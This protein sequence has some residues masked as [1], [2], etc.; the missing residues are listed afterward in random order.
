MRSGGGR[1]FTSVPFFEGERAE[2]SPAYSGV[3]ARANSNIR[4]LST[5]M[6]PSYGQ[7]NSDS[8]LPGQNGLPW[9]WRFNARWHK[10]WSPI[11]ALRGQAGLI[12]SRYWIELQRQYV[13]ARRAVDPASSTGRCP[14]ATKTWL[15]VACLV[16]TVGGNQKAA[17]RGRVEGTGQ[18]P[19]PNGACFPDCVHPHLGSRSH[20]QIAWLEGG[21]PR[22]SMEAGLP[23]GGGTGVWADRPAGV[24]PV[25]SQEGHGAE[26]SGDGCSPGWPRDIVAGFRQGARL[27]HHSRGRAPSWRGRRHPRPNASTALA[28]CRPLS[29]GLIARMLRLWP[30]HEEA[31]DAHDQVGSSEHGVHQCCRPLTAEGPQ[32]EDGADREVGQGCAAGSGLK[33]IRVLPWVAGEADALRH[34]KSPP[35]RRAHTRGRRR[36]QTCGWG[37]SSRPSP[38][39]DEREREAAGGIE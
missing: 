19:S 18:P 35:D 7:I 4:L 34:E 26:G 14:A 1:C 24:Q 33:M 10:A 20:A 23:G 30:I 37:W 11:C 21:C 9:T 6:G 13:S 15:K 36:S 39:P 5:T 3:S 25:C 29:A 27:P 17:L 28:T 38:A 16:E 22:Y 32:D 31:G 2:R 12:H 8:G